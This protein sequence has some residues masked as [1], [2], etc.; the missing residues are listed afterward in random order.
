MAQMLS[1]LHDPD[2]R[3]PGTVA[4]HCTACGAFISWI[5]P[6]APP[7]PVRCSGCREVTR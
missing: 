5:S 7:V 3:P 4:L 6:P 1:P 2:R